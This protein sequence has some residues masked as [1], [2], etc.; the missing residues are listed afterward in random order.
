VGGRNS[1]KK[2]SH[3]ERN[4]GDRVEPGLGAK[5]KILPRKLKNPKKNQKKSIT[6]KSKGKKG[7]C[8]RAC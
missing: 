5:G 2:N 4:E 1:R 3:Q 7:R 6:G 8:L